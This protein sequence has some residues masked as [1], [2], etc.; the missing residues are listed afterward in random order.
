[1]LNLLEMPWVFSG[2]AEKMLL[3]S[4]IKK[5]AKIATDESLLTKRI[6][7][8]SNNNEQS[9]WSVHGDA[10]GPT[11]MSLSDRSWHQL[12]RVSFFAE[13]LLH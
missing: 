7:V 9:L 2:C 1:M 6:Y 8:I 11:G 4:D 10:P 13:K 3:L 12:K 5:V